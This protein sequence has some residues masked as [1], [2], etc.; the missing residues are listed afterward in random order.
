MGF[1]V[2][3]ILGHLNPLALAE[4]IIP[5]PVVTENYLSSIGI[6][7]SRSPLCEIDRGLFTIPE[8]TSPTYRASTGFGAYLPINYTEVFITGAF[9]VLCLGI[10]VYFVGS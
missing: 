3:N 1:T 8:G 10:K 5:E 7:T 2:L 6:N 9:T 4:V